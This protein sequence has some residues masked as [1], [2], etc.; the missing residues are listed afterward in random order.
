M[1]THKSAQ[2][3]QNKLERIWPTLYMFSYGQD[4]VW[5]YIAVIF[6]KDTCIYAFILARSRLGLLP[7]IFHKYIRV[8][9]LD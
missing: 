5:D 3:L 8:I 7:V 6:L 4:L 9:V 1:S 2:N